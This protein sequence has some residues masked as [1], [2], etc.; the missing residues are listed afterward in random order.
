MR[1]RR[2]IRP[3]ALFATM[4]AMLNGGPYGLEE[5]IPLAGPGLAL[6][7]LSATAILWA[8]PYALIV[9]E[10]VSALPAEGGVYQWFRAGLGPFWSF[11]FAMLDWLT[12]VL[13]AALYPPLVAAYI[14]GLFAHDPGRYFS[15]GISLLVIWGSTWLNVRGVKS[16]GSLSIFITVAVLVPL[17]AMIALGI[18]HI[19]LA[20]LRPWIPEGRSFFTALNYALIWSLWSYSGYGALAS[21]GEEMVQPERN[22]PRALAFFVPLSLVIFVL[23]LL[24]ALGVSPDWQN[25][26]AA[27]FN[28]TASVIGGGWLL[29]AS[30]VGVQISNLGMFNAELL[31]I[32][33]VPYAIARDNL[34][35]P[36]LSRLHPRHGTP[37]RILILSGILF[38][39]LTFFFD[40]V[41]ILVA[42]T[43]IALP[44]YLMTFASPI[45]LRWKHP[46]I[47]G[48]FRIPGGWPVLLVVTLIPSAIALYVLLTV[49]TKHVLLGLGF[50]TAIPLTYVLSRRFHPRRTSPM[51]AGPS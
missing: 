6:L 4:F 49:E 35:P 24:V 9:A 26:S 15:W 8:V 31:V 19:P 42:S 7:V 40:F 23:P 47:R 45:I 29:A 28:Q 36:A 50:M 21:A 34:L 11:Q 33:R 22:Y 13:D 18:S 43:W 12:W 5:V 1:L 37:A 38:S 30:V 14:V 44:T 48:P 41:Q 46:E 10:L 25:W 20:P 32:S 39:L 3:L 16:V 17:F 51:S 2:E 27:Q